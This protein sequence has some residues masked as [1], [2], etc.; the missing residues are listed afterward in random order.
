MTETIAE[1]ITKKVASTFSHNQFKEY[2]GMTAREEELVAFLKSGKFSLNALS[3][4]T[5]IE[6][7]RIQHFKKRRKSLS[8]SEISMLYQLVSR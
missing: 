6:K 4:R 1:K 7:G 3:G 2:K 5:G 8:G